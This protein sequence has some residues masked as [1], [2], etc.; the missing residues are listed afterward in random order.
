[1]ITMKYMLQKCGQKKKMQ[2]VMTE[3]MKMPD[4]DMNKFFI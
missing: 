1:M 2:L 4:F 3:S